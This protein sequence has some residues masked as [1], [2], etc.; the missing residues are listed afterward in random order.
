MSR[1]TPYTGVYIPL[2]VLL[3][4]LLAGRAA[5]H[6]DED[7]SHDEEPAAK[8]LPGVD[9]SRPQ[10]LADGSLFVP[11]PTQRRLGLRTQ[12][13]NLATLEE[14]LSLNGTVI[15][16][17]AASGRVQSTQ[18]GR[19]AAPAKGLPV[20]GQRVR[21]GEILAWLNP[22]VS[23]LERG[24]QQALLADLQAQTSIAAQRAVRLEQLQGAV[25]QKDIE[26]ARL[27]LQAL[28]QRHAAI[29]AGIATTEPLHAPVSGVISRAEV[30]AGQVVEAREV[31]FEVVDPTR[32]MVE[33]LSYATAPPG[34]F[35]D[36]VAH[37]AGSP[38]VPLRFVGA[39]PG[40]REQ[41]RPLLFRVTGSNASLAIGQPLQ[42]IANTGRQ[43]A[44]V[45]VP[46]LALVKNA[47]GE[48]SVWLHTSA[49]HYTPRA[50]KWSP[51]D[52]ERVAVIDGLGDGER[53]VV[54]G[55][56]LLMQIR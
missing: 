49:E 43:F 46:R 30:V 47:T 48:D 16:D 14:A 53:I 45:A 52:A 20:I 23:S 17:P 51:L 11:K 27:E 21:K 13:A 31:L 12:L 50:V 3:F 15:G 28:Q 37:I 19:V 44:G 2:F 39:S 33:A 54:Q 18:S 56:S 5:A 7:H 38:G 8:A 26:A 10:R 36:A 24:N 40:L 9:A 41:A 35:G 29:G 25:P 32:L 34:R 55:A 1:H 4:A 6:G 22:A 42:V